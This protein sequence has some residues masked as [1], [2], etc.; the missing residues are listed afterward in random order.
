MIAAIT[1]RIS[2]MSRELKIF[3]LVSFVLS[4][5]YSLV[6]STFNNYLNERFQLTGFQRSFLELPREFP[7]V[8]VIFVSAM[9]WFLCSRRLGA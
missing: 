6:D 1:A 4:V 8:M 3:V 7:G 2:S 5:S 9:V